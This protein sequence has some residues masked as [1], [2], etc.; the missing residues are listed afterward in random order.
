MLMMLNLDHENSPAH[1]FKRPL[2]HFTDHVSVDSEGKAASRSLVQAYYYINDP[3]RRSMPV[4]ERT[5]RAITSVVS[6]AGDVRRKIKFPSTVTV[7]VTTF[8][9]VWSGA[10]SFLKL[11]DIS[12]TP[13]VPP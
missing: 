1:R 2:F 6:Q 5:P 9:D 10:D 13:A 7:K 12:H 3:C 8:A 4:V 11:T